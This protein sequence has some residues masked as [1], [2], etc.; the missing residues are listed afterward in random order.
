M[1]LMACSVIVATFG[2]LPQGPLSWELYLVRALSVL[3]ESVMLLYRADK[4]PSTLRQKVTEETS[5]ISAKAGEESVFCGPLCDNTGVL[6]YAEGSCATNSEIS[7]MT[8]MVEGFEDL[9]DL[10]VDIKEVNVYLPSGQRAELLG[11]G[12]SGILMAVVYDVLLWWWRN[13]PRIKFG[14]LRFLHLMLVGASL[15]YSGI[16]LET[17]DPSWTC[18]CVTVVYTHVYTCPDLFSTGWQLG[19]I[20]VAFALRSGK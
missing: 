11:L 10:D 1:E 5:A 18:M 19:S 3:H 16:I 9:G 4:V 20:Q 13:E 2:G 14:Q 6:R 8:W 17:F 15:S 7:E 12:L